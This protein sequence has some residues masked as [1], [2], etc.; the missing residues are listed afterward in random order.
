MAAGAKRE[1]IIRNLYQ[2]Q[3]IGA[4]KLWGRILMNLKTDS[5]QKIAW[6]VINKEDFQQTNARPE[7]I[8]GAIN[9]LIVSIPSVELTTIFY[10]HDNS[11]K[12]L[13]K[14][15]KEHNLKNIFQEFRPNGEKQIITF[16][17]NTNHQYILD[18][19]NQLI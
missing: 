15:E 2:K 16:E 9:E 3:T 7:D 5:Q 18:K 1:E 11:K 10:E 12:A 6:A 14:T 8:L 19:L 17:L 13:I 4:L